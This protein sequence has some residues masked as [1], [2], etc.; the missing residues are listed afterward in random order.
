MGAGIPRSALGDDASLFV[1]VF[2]AAPLRYVDLM[3]SSGALARVELEGQLELRTMIDLPELESE[4]TL[5][6]RAVQQDGHAAWTSPY[7]LD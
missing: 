6:V 4:D 2:A 5:W 3:G 7:F 1:E